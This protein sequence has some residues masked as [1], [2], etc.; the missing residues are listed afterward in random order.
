MFLI[1]SQGV[2]YIIGDENSIDGGFMDHVIVL[3][4]LPER[5][6]VL[7]TF[8]DNVTGC[9]VVVVRYIQEDKKRFVSKGWID[10]YN[11]QVVIVILIVVCCGEEFVN[12]N[13]G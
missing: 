10:Q 6:Y 12:H 8:A 11:V 1:Q 7:Q 5:V 3:I 4:I 9:V 13:W 2:R